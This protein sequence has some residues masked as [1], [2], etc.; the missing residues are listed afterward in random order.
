MNAPDLFLLTERGLMLLAGSLL[1][2]ICLPNLLQLVGWHRFHNGI[3]GGPSDVEPE[4]KGD[5]Y[6]HYYGQLRQLGFEP[7]GVYWEQVIFGRPSQ[8][9]AFVLPKE[10]CQAIVYRLAGGDFRV[11]F[12][13]VFV[14]GAL[15]KTCNYS[16][17]PQKETDCLV[18]GVPTQNLMTALAEH[19]QAVAR[20]RLAGHAPHDCGTLEAFAEAESM[21]FFNGTVQREYRAAQWIILLGKLLFMGTVPGLM[22]FVSTWR[23][24]SSRVAWV[25]LSLLAIGYLVVEK[26]G[27][28]Q[29]TQALTAE[30]ESADEQS[31]ANS[32]RR[33]GE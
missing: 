23:G 5:L 4:G 18:Q 7:L 24:G 13:T 8:E 27:L 29:A 25:T 1:L 3:Y 12:K 28:R 30:Q 33:P 19:R 6:A 31:A 14:D 11:V 22:L 16:R 21:S 15:V 26:R 2:A 20:F 17:D 10:N 32:E 9:F